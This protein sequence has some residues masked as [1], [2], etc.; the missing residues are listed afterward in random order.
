MKRLI[1]IVV[2]TL[3]CFVLVEAQNIRVTKTYRLTEQKGFYPKFNSDGSMLAFSSPSYKGLE[4]Y[5]FSDK[6]TVKVSEEEGTGLDPIF[7]SDNKKIFYKKI[8]YD[9]KLRKESV[10]S[11]SFANRKEEQIVQ[12]RRNVKHPQVLQ[13]EVAVIADNQMIKSANVNKDASVS[14]YVWSDG[15]NL[16][17]YRNDKTEALNPVEGANGYIWASLSPNNKMILFTA[18]GR[19]TFVCN[20]EGKVIA[21][22]GY[23]NAPVWYND[24]L[25]IGMRD[26][27]DGEVVTES[28]IVMKSIKGKNEK[29]ISPSGMIALYPTVAPSV[30]K[31]AYNTD[32]G[33][34][35]IAELSITK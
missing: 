28:S 3:L 25:V 4:V 32:K 15:R 18:V 26:K 7:S 23:L 1:F 29:V 8:N 6:S 31:I 35:Y 33:D 27:D 19:G 10:K 34:I 14:N 22:L 13:N 9:T 20:L 16:N 17:I 2:S 11:Y 24:E 5:R 30:G 12:P 21:S